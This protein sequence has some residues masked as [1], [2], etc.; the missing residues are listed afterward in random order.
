MDILIELAVAALKT[1]VSGTIESEIGQHLANRGIDIGSARFRQYI[2]KT[3][4]GLN[5]VLRD[6]SL[7]DMKIPEGRTTY[8]R[9]E[10]RELLR[11]ISLEETLL[12]ECRYNAQSLGKVLYKKYRQ[13][14]KNSVEYEGEIRKVISAISEKVISIE[15][16]RK[17]FIQDIL[18]NLVNSN[19]EIKK[20]VNSINNYGTPVQ[21]QLER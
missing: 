15:K 20:D 12:R 9:E 14:K 2:E 13:Q 10:I 4:K 11:S 8:I 1:W 16:E 7:I 21:S 18:I 3:Q 19:E 17:G 6:E 5:E